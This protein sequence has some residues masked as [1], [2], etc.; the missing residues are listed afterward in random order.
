[1]QLLDDAHGVGGAIEEIGVAEGDVL[2]SGRHLICDVLQHDVR[3]HDEEPAAVDRDN[4]AVAAEML[5][6][7]A[8]LGVPGDTRAVTG[9]LDVC[10][11]LESGKQTTIGNQEL[12]PGQRD[13]RFGLGSNGRGPYLVRNEPLNQLDEHLQ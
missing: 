2:G 11:S 7:A 6:A 4:W 9:K 8:G 13:R 1:M 10:V 12:L 3:L 5:A